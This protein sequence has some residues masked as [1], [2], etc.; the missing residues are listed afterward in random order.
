[1]VL[2]NEFCK[3]IA[4]DRVLGRFSFLYRRN[5][6]LSYHFS[7]LLAALN[8]VAMVDL[9]QPY[10]DHMEKVNTFKSPWP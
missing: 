4:T 9:Q 8:E 7:H 5:G 3:Q 1:M 2:N 6:A 10:C